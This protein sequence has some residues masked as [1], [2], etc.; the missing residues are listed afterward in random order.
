MFD[1]IHRSLQL[2]LVIINL[3][4]KLVEPKTIAS[5]K[6]IFHRVQSFVVQLKDKFRRKRK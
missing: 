3:L 6:V 5:M 2:A 4:V 1:I